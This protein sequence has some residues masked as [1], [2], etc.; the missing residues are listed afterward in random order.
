[1]PAPPRGRCA[2]GVAVRLDQ[3][4]PR[5]V[6]EIALTHA[7]VARTAAE[8]DPEHPLR[9]RR[10]RERHLVLDAERPVHLA[11][12]VETVEVAPGDDVGEPHGA[13]VPRAQ[14]ALDERVLRAVAGERLVDLGWHGRIRQGYGARQVDRQLV[15]RTPLGRDLLAQRPQQASAQ[16]LEVEQAHDLADHREHTAFERDRNRWTV[17]AYVQG[18]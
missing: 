2:R 7:E 4:R 1:V 11:V 10:K 13:T 3:V 14:V 5:E 18:T 16:L 17:H 8:R 9:R 6:Q 12:E 15:E